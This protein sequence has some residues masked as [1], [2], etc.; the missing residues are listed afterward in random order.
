MLLFFFKSIYEHFVVQNRVGNGDLS[1][2][3]ICKKTA[4]HIFFTK[5]YPQNDI[6]LPNKP[7]KNLST[8][9][10]RLGYVPL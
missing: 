7:E 2:P 8:K 9:A 4:I 1:Q 6:M 3:S 10:D 5:T